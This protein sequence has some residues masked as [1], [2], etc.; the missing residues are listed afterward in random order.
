MVKN[1]APL[2]ARLPDIRRVSLREQDHSEP[3]EHNSY[4]TAQPQV[5]KKYKVSQVS[6]STA[7]IDSVVSHCIRSG[8]SLI[9]TA[10]DK[11]L[12]VFDSHL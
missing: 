6:Q 7:Q 5:R 11:T 12:R 3:I 4:E 2:R 9:T 1:E 10:Y 8:D